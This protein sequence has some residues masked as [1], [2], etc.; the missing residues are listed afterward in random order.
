MK[1]KNKLKV[2]TNNKFGI[3]AKEEFEKHISGEKS[4]V[5]F[6]GSKTILNEDANLTDV[7]ISI[8]PNIYSSTTYSYM[9]IQQPLQLIWKPKEDITTYELA[10]CIPYI[11][12]YHIMPSM[13]DQTQEFL[14]HFEII[15]H[16]KKL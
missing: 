4:E 8:N 11:N 15:D 7:S 13:I 16:N 10:L 5:T 6:T 2:D 12:L 1:A 9:V 14:R 3:D